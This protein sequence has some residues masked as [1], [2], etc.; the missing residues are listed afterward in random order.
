M[1]SQHP[2]TTTL[3][4]KN[5][6]STEDKLQMMIFDSN[7]KNLNQYKLKPGANVNNIKSAKYGDNLVIGYTTV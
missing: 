6:S 4:G 2:S 5:Y 3:G 7:F 1:H